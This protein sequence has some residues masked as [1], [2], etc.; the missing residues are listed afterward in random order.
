MLWL[1]CVRPACTGEISL[2][3]L[4]RSLPIRS[5]AAAALL[6]LILQGGGGAAAQIA[7]TSVVATPNLITRPIDEA[8]CTTLK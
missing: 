3:A 7:G 1:P 2:T 6:A 5:A 4:H 8:Q